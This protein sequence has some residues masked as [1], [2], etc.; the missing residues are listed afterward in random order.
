MNGRSLELDMV[1]GLMRDTSRTQNKENCNDLWGIRIRFAS[2]FGRDFRHLGCTI[3]EWSCM[4]LT[5]S[6]S[7][8]K[9]KD[10]CIKYGLIENWPETKT[11]LYEPF[12]RLGFNASLMRQGYSRKLGQFMDTLPISIAVTYDC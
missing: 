12:C 9:K 6:V 11:S 4:K 5:G 10:I 1:R 2:G 3:K 8:G 7:F